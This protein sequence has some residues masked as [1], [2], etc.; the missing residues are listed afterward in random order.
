VILN[1]GGVVEEQ[2]ESSG[3]FIKERWAA[4]RE[5]NILINANRRLKNVL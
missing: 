5:A 3:P 4:I 2:D 1:Q